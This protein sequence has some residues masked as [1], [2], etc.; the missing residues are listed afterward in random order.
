MPRGYPRAS[1]YRGSCRRSTLGSSC[2]RA[3][4]AALGEAGSDCRTITR[5]AGLV[6]A[7]RR[8]APAVVVLRI[9]PV[10]FG[11]AERTPCRRS[12][13]GAV[14]V[15]RFCGATPACTPGA[16][17]ADLAMA[18]SCRRRVTSASAASR[19]LTAASSSER[20]VAASARVFTSSSNRLARTRLSRA[21]SSS[22]DARTGVVQ[23]MPSPT[24]AT[25]AKLIECR[26]PLNCRCDIGGLPDGPSHGLIISEGRSCSLGV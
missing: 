10:A 4:D 16:G 19:A 3:I 7:T 9:A 23:A 1:D 5:G 12:A 2:V 21:I 17:L 18:A 6:R 26:D 20:A 24:A 14:F 13:G 22:G 8:C 11:G 15:V 25:T